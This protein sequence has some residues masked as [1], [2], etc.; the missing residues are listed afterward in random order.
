MPKNENYES[1]WWRA[2]KG[3]RRIVRIELKMCY[4]CR[5]GFSILIDTQSYIC[6]PSVPDIASCWLIQAHERKEMLVLLLLVKYRAQAYPR[7]AHS[8]I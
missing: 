6:H 3:D 4:S 8:D 5:T 7:K 1:F 2:K